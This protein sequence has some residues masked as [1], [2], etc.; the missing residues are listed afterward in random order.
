[1]EGEMMMISVKREKVIFMHDTL[2]ALKEEKIK[3]L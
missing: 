1:M 2:P 3:N